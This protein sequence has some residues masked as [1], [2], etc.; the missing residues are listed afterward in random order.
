MISETIS[1]VNL[2]SKNNTWIKIT[3]FK[4]SHSTNNLNESDFCQNLFIT[5]YITQAQFFFL[6]AFRKH[7]I[8]TF[9]STITALKA[10]N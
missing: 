4:T 3:R 6:I 5:G 10:L 8:T 1:Y 2:N 9:S 7:T